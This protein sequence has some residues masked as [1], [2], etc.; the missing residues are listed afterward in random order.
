MTI[1]YFLHG[2]DAREPNESNDRF[3]AAV[4]NSY[5]TKANIL[6]VQFAASSEKQEEYWQL[7]T[8]QFER[9]KEARELSYRLAEP[10]TFL[11]QISWADV[12]YFGGAKSGTSI[13]LSA[14]S[15]YPQ[16][17]SHFTGKTV[18]GESAGANVLA[19]YCYSRSGGVIQGLGCVPVV[20]VPHYQPGDEQPV[21]SLYPDL[22]HLYLPSYEFKSFTL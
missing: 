15:H 2:G 20:F 3:F 19:A 12:I 8:A 9:V 22:E 13:L 7:H 21:A 10:E 1:N 4:L 5:S 16:L 6:L 11:D 14:L 17:C 18:A